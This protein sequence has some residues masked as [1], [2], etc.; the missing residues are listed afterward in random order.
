[1]T[2]NIII[3]D[4]VVT[5]FM[6]QENLRLILFLYYYLQKGRDLGVTDIG[7]PRRW[8]LTIFGK[9]K[10]SNEI[11]TLDPPVR[12]SSICRLIFLRTCSIWMSPSTRVLLFFAFPSL[13][14]ILTHGSF[15]I[16]PERWHSIY[17]NGSKSQLGL[18]GEKSTK[19]N[20]T[21]S[22]HRHC[23]KTRSSIW[24]ICAFTPFHATAA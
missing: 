4:K 7:Q 11:S 8:L 19:S 2:C 21:K 6:I 20:R 24:P 22:P 13:L 17:D 10:I 23:W 16:G 9:R 5:C 3:I 15:V 12:W 18:S 14:E 1:M